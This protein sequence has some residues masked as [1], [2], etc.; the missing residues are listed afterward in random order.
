MTVCYGET[1]GILSG[2]V[3]SMLG[4]WINKEMENTVGNV[5]IVL[6]L[7]IESTAFSVNKVKNLQ[8]CI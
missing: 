1:N 2:E 8:L 5:Q 6:S 3:S 4:N 7:G